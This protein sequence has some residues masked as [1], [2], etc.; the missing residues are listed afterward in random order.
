MRYESFDAEKDSVLSVA[1]M[2]LASIRTA[3]K[4]KGVDSIESVIID[5]DEKKALANELKKMASEFGVPSF[6]RDA[7]NLDDSTCVIIVGV[8]NEYFGASPCGNCGL[9]DCAEA[10]KIG[11]MCSFKTV[12]LGIAIG[13]AV[14]IAAVHHIDNRVMYTIGQA[15]K[16]LNILSD[17][18]AVCF[19]IPLSATRKNIYFDR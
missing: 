9:K 11:A 7:K 19:G 16:R 1:K 8:R 18:I 15:A 2:M 12:D 14:S 3:P 13:S 5:G 4:G 10:S 6:E 17:K